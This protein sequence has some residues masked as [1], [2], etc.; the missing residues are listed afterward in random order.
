MFVRTTLA[1]EIVI[2]QGGLAPVCFVPCISVLTRT[3]QFD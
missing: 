1:M 2:A 3:D